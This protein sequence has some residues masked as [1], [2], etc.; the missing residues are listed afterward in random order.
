M[1]WN[2][3]S[4]EVML[5]FLKSFVCIIHICI[6]LYVLQVLCCLQHSANSC[7]WLFTV[8]LWAYSGNGGGVFVLGL[9][10]SLQPADGHSL[11]SSEIIKGP[12]LILKASFIIKSWKRV[13]YVQAWGSTDGC[14][15]FA[16][17]CL[18]LI[19]SC[20]YGPK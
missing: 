4:A 15:H 20:T 12:I 8:D 1:I 13:Q 9:S 19:D 10:F 16:S 3:G 14:R 6:F 11:Y 18:C 7:R 2:L 17:G 5:S